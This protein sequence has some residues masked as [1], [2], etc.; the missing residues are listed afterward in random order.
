MTKINLALTFLV[1]LAIALL[2]GGLLRSDL[3]TEAI[4]GENGEGLSTGMIVSPLIFVGLLL[5]G[6]AFGWH[7]YGRS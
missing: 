3:S 6:L 2:I 7:K 5:I 4:A 1:V